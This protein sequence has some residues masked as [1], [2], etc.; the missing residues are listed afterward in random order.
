MKTFSFR[1]KISINQQIAFLKKSILSAFIILLSFCASLA[2]GTLTG[3]V[4]DDEFDEP[5]EKAVVTIPGTLISVLTDQQGKFTM[6]M[7]AGDYLLEVNYPGYFSKKYNM[8]VYKEITTPMFI[9]KLK[10]NK[11]GRAE[12]RRITSHENKRQ[13]PQNI[14]DFST[15]QITEQTGHQEFNELIKT[16]PSAT[17]TSNGSGFSDSEIGFRGNN[18]NRTTYTL[19]GILLNNPET[20]RVG[21]AMLSGLTDWAG[22]IQVVSGQAANLQSRTN[23]GGLINILSFVPHE[24]AGA[25]VLAV[26]GNHGFLKTSAT[27]YSGLSKKGLS[28]SVQISKTSGNGLAQNTD[29]KQYGFFLNIQKEYNQMHT[30]TFNL[31]GTV[32]QHD[33]NASD[34]IGAYNL[35]GTKYNQLGGYLNNKPMSWST[36]YA[37]SPL[38]SLTHF[39]RPR[40][41][42]YI[43]TQIYAQFN[44]S[45]QLFPG[46]SPTEVIPRDTVGLISFDKITNWNIGLNVSELGAVRLPDANGKYVNTERSGISTLAAI[47]RENR[48]GLRSVLIHNFNKKLHLNVGFDLEQYHASHF[49]AVTNLLGADSYTSYSDV[50]RPDGFVVENKFIPGFFKSYNSSDKTAYFYESNIQSGGLSLRINYQTSRFYWYFEGSASL[51]NFGRTDHFNYLT[52]DTV[53]QPTFNLFPGG[54]AQTGLSVNFW[55]YHS[56]HLRV[57]YGSHQPLFQ[58]LFPFGNN[59]KNDQI[60]NEQVFDTEFGYTIFSRKLKIEASAYQSMVF[61]R[62]IVGLANLNSYNSYGLVNGLE[63]LHRGIELKTSYKITGNIQL[64]LNTSLGDWKYTKNVKVQNYDSNNLLKSENEL[65]L[66]NVQIPNAPQFTIYAEAEWRWAH[67]FYVRLNY[68][69]ADQLYAPFLI[70][71]FRLN[72]SM[73]EPIYEAVNVSG[74]KSNAYTNKQIN[75]P[76]VLSDSKQW[77]LP[78]SQLLGISGNYLRK[79]RKLLTINF[80]FGVNNLLDTEYIEQSATNLSEG[81]PHYTAN[82]VYYGT[83]RTWFTGC[84]FQF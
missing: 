28:S 5:L 15:W 19:N 68:Y 31:Y 84:K 14:E 67:N 61:N 13:F 62:S 58:N 1:R 18:S 4:V 66:K 45:A 75:L 48:F 54:R 34:S 52:T 77:K 21:S 83:G 32:Q 71:N 64:N 16:I 74:S 78:A 63:E 12:Q 70:S 35:Y 69:R 38:I 25:E 37:R 39:W 33:Q 60:T 3:F 80:F 81:N 7:V 29:F 11:V 27:V 17:Y 79:I 57:S 24:K 55:K 43:T 73:A 44:R 56:V 82:Q 49:G 47:D 9:I 42:T 59:Q 8:S 10:A 72:Y 50:N 2:Q 76:F 30:V 6:K 53:K 26:Y 65:A 36:N 41:K 40:I 51:Q 22:Q 20:G 46:K 23:A